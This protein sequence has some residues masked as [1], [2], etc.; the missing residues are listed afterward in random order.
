MI[1]DNE[2][3]EEKKINIFIKTNQPTHLLAKRKR[4]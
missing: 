1:F 3:E 4:L 2:E